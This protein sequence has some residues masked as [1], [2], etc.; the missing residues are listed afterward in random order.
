LPGEKSPPEN[1]NEILG[2][3]VQALVETTTHLDRSWCSLLE[4]LDSP[5][6]PGHILAPLACTA[7]RLLEQGNE[8]L[9]L[10]RENT[11]GYR[12]ELE[13]PAETLGRIGRELAAIEK[14]FVPAGPDYEGM[15]RGLA[16]AEHGEGEASW[17]VL[18]RFQGPDKV[19]A[20]DIASN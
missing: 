8:L 16:E 4:A 7:R 12:E 18:A 6:V 9:L 13:G 14:V 1:L 17:T 15:D 20:T 2:P 3:V 5:G 19:S 11:S 10:L